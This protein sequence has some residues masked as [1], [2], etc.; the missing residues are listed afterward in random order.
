MDTVST[1]GRGG[2]ETRRWGRLPWE[3]MKQFLSYSGEA[4]VQTEE[5]WTWGR[6]WDLG[7]SE[8]APQEAAHP[9]SPILGSLPLPVSAPLF[10]TLGIL[11]RRGHRKAQERK[12]V[13]YRGVA[14]VCQG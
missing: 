8:Q 2:T 5:E 11:D 9:W 7:V 13:G 12:K 10:N 6:W 1:L 4:A 3:T 14:L